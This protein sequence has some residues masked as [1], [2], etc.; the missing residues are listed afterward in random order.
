MHLQTIEAAPSHRHP[1]H[2]FTLKVIL[3]VSTLIGMV[4]MN[5][6]QAVR[7]VP[8]L[9]YDYALAEAQCA[10][11][12]VSINVGG[13]QYYYSHT[14][15][16]HPTG[17]RIYAAWY[18]AFYG[19]QCQ[20]I[21][22]AWNN[23]VCWVPVQQ[24]PFSQPVCPQNSLLDAG[25]AITAPMASYS[26]D[27]L[28][29]AQCACDAG[30]VPDQV[31]AA[32]VKCLAPKFIDPATGRCVT[33]IYTLSLTPLSATIEPSKSTTLIATVT[34]DFNEV[35]SKPIPVTVAVKVDAKSGGHD[36]GNASRPKGTLSTTSG[37][38]SFPIT[39]SATDASGTHTIT[40]TCELCVNKTVDAV[41]TVKVE[42]LEQI[43]DSQ[44]YQLYERVGNTS[45]YKA[46]GE[47]A[48]HRS[49]HYLT[50]AA[51]EKLWRIATAYRFTPIFMQAG[52]LP[53]PLHV[54]DASLI[55]GGKFDLSGEWVGHHF[56][57]T[58]GTVVDIRA[59]N[60]DTAMPAANFEDFQSLA[61][62][63]GADAHL[64]SPS[65]GNRHFH[66]RLLNR[67]E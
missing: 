15:H 21:A 44:F 10:G 3:I 11:L 5:A 28:A 60:A 29:D 61:E 51:S 14:Y 24:K 2:H 53:L 13:P 34:K 41:V 17:L 65:I 37:N 50:L 26:P 40:A 57:H 18:T 32:C 56:E 52:V 8:K 16:L 23:P 4:G 1:A 22:C 36:H 39:F 27:T 42:G 19:N 31:G 62:D 47:T 25:L 30:Y 64:E 38:T 45:A 67:Q 48:K 35:P 20:G 63:Y 46:I 59:N 33:E 58:R 43:P 54:N 7:S 12:S 55:W 49:N 6:A 66:L 9:N